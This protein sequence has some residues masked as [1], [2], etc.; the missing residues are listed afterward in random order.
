MITTVLHFFATFFSLF[1]NC[2]HFFHCFASAYNCCFPT[3]LQVFTNVFHCFASVNNIFYCFTSVYSIFYCLTSVYNCFNTVLQV[4]KFILQEFTTVFSIFWQVIT[5][6]ALHFHCFI[7]DSNGLPL[8]CKRL[9]LFFTI[10]EAFTTF[11]TV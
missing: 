10:Y 3:V 2:L 9:Q 7:S 6:N 1:Y 4:F 8:F 5:T 11:F